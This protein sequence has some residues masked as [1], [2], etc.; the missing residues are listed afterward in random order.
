MP[1]ELTSALIFVETKPSGSDQATKISLVE[2]SKVCL[3]LVLQLISPGII[4][5]T[6]NTISSVTSIDSKFM[7]QLPPITSAV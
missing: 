3:L 7:H 4:V 2:I 6:G 5:P 1:G